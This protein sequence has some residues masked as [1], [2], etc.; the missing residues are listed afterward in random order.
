M[1]GARAPA[2]FFG[3]RPAVRAGTSDLYFLATTMALNG[4]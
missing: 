3:A 2:V 1:A 4:G